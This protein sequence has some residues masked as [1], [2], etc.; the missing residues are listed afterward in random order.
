MIC[1]TAVTFGDGPSPGSPC[2]ARFSSPEA[3]AGTRRRP[4]ASA[5]PG[6]PA[7]CA[8]RPSRS[9]PG[10]VEQVDGQLLQA[11]HLLAHRVHEL[12]P[13]LLV[14]VLVLE[15]LDEAGQRE[16]RCA[17]LVRGGGNELL[18]RDV[19]LLLC[20]ALK[21]RVSWPSSS[22]ESTGSGSPMWPRATSAAAC[23]TRRTR[24][25]SRRAMNQPP[26]S[27]TSSA[28]AQAQSTRPRMKE[29][30]SATSA[31]LRE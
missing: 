1:I 7:R 20:I 15:Q 5:R 21:V 8:A 10:Q 24:R 14:E 16:D 28:A 30:V 29:T 6:R 31:K 11:L 26:I 13:R 3:P 23:S 25:A 2:A 4:S 12:A 22:S 18:A 27:A 19:D 9:R 17:Q